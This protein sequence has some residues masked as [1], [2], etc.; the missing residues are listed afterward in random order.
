MGI[1]LPMWHRGV[2]RN[3][4]ATMPGFM[5]TR[6]TQASHRDSPSLCFMSVNF[7]YLA[8]WDGGWKRGLSV[9][10]YVYTYS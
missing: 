8:G 3:S 1:D 10:G 9:R 4:G 6:T 5:P 2:I 7:D